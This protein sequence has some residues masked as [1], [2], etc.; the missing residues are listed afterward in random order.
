MDSL[1]KTLHQHYKNLD[2]IYNNYAKENGLSVS[3]FWILYSIVQSES[4][5]TQSEMINIWTFTQQTVN[6]SLK[7][8]EKDGLIE[9][10]T[11]SENK[12]NK[13]IYLTKAG[14]ELT[15]KIINPFIQA[16]KSAAEKFSPEMKNLYAEFIKNHFE[17]LSESLKNNHPEV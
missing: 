1:I 11:S 10:K 9:F 8:L 5:L 17:Y 12:K 6:T 14:K 2:S 13:Y 16:E 4:P 3:S 7:N 15:E